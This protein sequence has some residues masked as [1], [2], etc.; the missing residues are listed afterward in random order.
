LLTF[1]F[2]KNKNKKIFL[3]LKKINSKKIL[4]DFI[5]ET[6]EKKT[7]IPFPILAFLDFFLQGKLEFKL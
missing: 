7:P 4:Y 1:F 5:L 6:Q 3:F 2:K